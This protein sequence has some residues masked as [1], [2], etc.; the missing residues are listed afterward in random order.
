MEKDNKIF[1][2][3]IL[4]SC[5]EITQFIDGLDEDEFLRNRQLQL[6]VIKSIE[7][8]G[9]A[10]K[11]LSS[12]FRKKYNHIPW[13]DMSGMRDKLTHGYMDV[14]YRTVWDVAVKDIPQLIS[15]IEKLL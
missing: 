5:N 9:E 8:I 1:L 12:E 10:T 14:N 3:H 13:D 15:A 7:I 4:K 2:G 6:A 11:R